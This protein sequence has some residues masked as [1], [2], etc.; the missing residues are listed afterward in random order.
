MPGRAAQLSRQQQAFET[1]LDQRYSTDPL[2]ASAESGQSRGKG[3]RRSKKPI[4]TVSDKRDS[5]KIP[6]FVLRESAFSQQTSQQ[7][8]TQLEQLYS[9]FGNVLDHTVI[10]RA[11]HECHHSVDAAIGELLA[12]SEHIQSEASTSSKSAD[13]TKPAGISRTGMR[14]MQ[15][16][17]GPLP[18]IHR[19]VKQQESI[20]HCLDRP[21]HDPSNCPCTD[22]QQPPQ[23]PL[24]QPASG[25]GSQRSARSLS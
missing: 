24:R 8:S 9:M 5:D 1:L 3:N 17:T 12:R 4:R 2:P 7:P 22:L 10:A 18:Y 20:A 21:T 11:L 16:L 6:G 14:Y 15:R 13:S 25:A 23:A 19:H